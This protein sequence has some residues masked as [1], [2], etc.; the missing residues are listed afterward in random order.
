VKPVNNIHALLVGLNGDLARELGS[1][2]RSCAVKTEAISGDRGQVDLQA[3]TDSLADLIFCDAH[4]GLVSDLR[5]AKPSAP[6]VVVS[7]HAEVNHWLDAIEAGATDYCA[8]PFETAQ[9]K[10]ILEAC[11]RSTTATAAAAAA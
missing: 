2:L 10:W 3:V 4:G 6:I 9:V 8:S 11:L 5:T 1:R 7:R